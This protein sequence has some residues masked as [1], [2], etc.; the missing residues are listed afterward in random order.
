MGRG[1]NKPKPKVDVSLAYEQR[2]GA[3]AET[4]YS[5]INMYREENA[6]LRESLEQAEQEV[7]RLTKIIH[8]T[9]FTT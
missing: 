2:M 6:R 7:K 5:L 8:Q 4:T 3:L 9:K 1:K